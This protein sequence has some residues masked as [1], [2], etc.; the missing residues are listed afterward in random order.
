MV[1]TALHRVTDVI[2]STLWPGS[3]ARDCGQK[4]HRRQL[5]KES[6]GESHPNF[7]N[8]PNLPNPRTR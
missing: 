3:A 4:Q 1:Y 8:F 7:P 6:A 5:R 2:D